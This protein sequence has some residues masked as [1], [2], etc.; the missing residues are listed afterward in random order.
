MY[1]KANS[2]L[3]KKITNFLFFRS[4]RFY[5]FIFFFLLVILLSFNYSYSMQYKSGDSVVVTPDQSIEENLFFTCE[6]FDFQGKIKGDIVG[7]CKTA[8]ISG[9]IEGDIWIA[10][11]SITIDANIT[12]STVIAAQQIDIDGVL[13]GEILGM[14]EEFKISENSQIK[15]NLLF[16]CK[17]LS[18]NGPLSKNAEGM[19]Q[20]LYIN[21]KIDGNVD[22]TLEKLELG[23]N[24]SIAGNLNYK[25]EV[26]IEK[27][28]ETKIIGKVFHKLPEPKKIESSVHWKII[29]RIIGII[30]YMIIGCIIILPFKKHTNMVILEHKKNLLL[31]LLIG[32]ISF[33]L[34]PI[35]IL[36]LCVTIIG[37]PLGLLIMM[38]F[39]IIWYI[40]PIFLMTYIGQLIIGIFKKDAT[41]SLF[42]SF[43]IGLVVLELLRM[44]P[45]IGFL[46]TVFIWFAGV[47]AFLISRKV[48]FSDLKSRGII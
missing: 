39:F 36:I 19:C 2:L 33:V 6:N 46:V 23:P 43:V 20:Y 22:A 42:C 18:I 44:V 45:Y 1:S 14:C 32:F 31:S 4:T 3:L 29:F 35:I 28:K 37:A 9:D 5:K 41:G 11:Q 8:K 26:L 27:G 16:Y 30:S 17:E 34:L 48:L 47:G 38:F 10:A 13:N 12:G 24:A 15:N 21:S 7:A 40:S 25:S